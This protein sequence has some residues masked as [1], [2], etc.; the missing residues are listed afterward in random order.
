[1]K[2]V[3]A[4]VATILIL[5]I[6]VSLAASAYV[7]FNSI[8]SST[9]QTGEKQIASTMQKLSTQFNVEGVKGNT[10]YVRNN[11]LGDLANLTVFVDNV[12]VNTSMP[13]I[14]AGET[15]SVTINSFIDYS[16]A[17]SMKV[18]AG[19]LFSS[20][21]LTSLQGY[22]NLVAY[23]KFDEPTGATSFA[24]SSGS[25]N[26]GSC[27]S[28]P[29]CPTSGATG[30]VNKAVT[31]DKIDDLMQVADSNSLK[32]TNKGS[33]EAWIYKNQNGGGIAQKTGGNGYFLEEWNDKMLFGW[34]VGNTQS[35]QVIPTGSWNHLAVT[36]DGAQLKIY[37]NGY[38]DKTQAYTGSADSGSRKL[39]I[40]T[41][42][43]GMKYGGMIDEFR[44][45]NRTLSADEITA[46][47]LE[48]K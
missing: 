27:F 29:S 11:G 20:L 35:N 37:I 30:K 16:S 19:A 38:L 6:T 13:T 36:Y 46:H 23:W 48:G 32:L 14:K 24:D 33:I 31:F 42:R 45:W 47:Y 5:L 43:S 12:L 34:G 25:R 15:G 1:M 17:K 10:V 41:D 44:I 40:G 7:W 2:G 28:V 39:Y 22:D 21:T 4:V 3:S 9:E 26:D 8:V 18:G